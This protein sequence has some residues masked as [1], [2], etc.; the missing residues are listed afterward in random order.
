[1][2]GALDLHDKTTVYPVAAWSEACELEFTTRGTM[3]SSVKGRGG[4]TL[5]TSTQVRA[6][7]IDDLVRDNPPTLITMDIE[8]AEYEAIV[9]A[10]RTIRDHRPIVAV[11]AYH[12][13]DDL[14]KKTTLLQEMDCGYRFFVRLHQAVAVD[15]VLYA[16]PIHRLTG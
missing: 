6:A 9:G 16:V 5:G 4:E 2:L 10:Q 11:S 13:R 8:G 1:M 3:R 7:A 15:V 12:R 14:P